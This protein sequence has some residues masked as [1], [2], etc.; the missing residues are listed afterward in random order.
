MVP[1]LDKNGDITY[2]S[3][4]YSMMEIDVS[5]GKEDFYDYI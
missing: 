5:G 4:N 2:L 3:D 1:F